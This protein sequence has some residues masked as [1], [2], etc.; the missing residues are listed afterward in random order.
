MEKYVLKSG[1]KDQSGPK[2][3]EVVHI[4]IDQGLNKWVY[5]IRWGG[6]QHSAFAGPSELSHLQALVKKFSGHEVHV[7]HE[8]CGFGYQISRWAQE[9]TEQTVRVTV[10]PPSTIEQE[11]GRR[12][13]TDRIDARKLARKL[14]LGELKGVWV[15]SVEQEQA[16]QIS[17]TQQQMAQ[18]RRRA[19]IRVR[20]LLRAHGYKAPPEAK[21][22]SAYERWLEQL[23]L[24]EALR[25]CAGHLRA[26]RKHAAASEQELLR[27]LRNMSQA[28]PYAKVVQTWTK[29]VVGIGW[30][31]A[32]RMLLELGD[33][34]RFP[35]RGSLP[36]YLGLTPSEYSTGD[37]VHRGAVLRCG[38]VRV[39][40]WLIES[41]WV[42]VR[43]DGQ[44]RELFFRI[45]GPS[46]ST[47]RR[48][49]AIVAI[50]HRLAI[51]LRALWKEALADS[52]QVQ[53]K[54]VA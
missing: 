27:Q 4:G 47:A 19:Q 33:V 22:W 16:R 18:E 32:I 8:A 10:V 3:G 38:P 41:A 42:A 36:H 5:A 25:Q 7:V 13:K 24:P 49:V 14:E 17:R 29:N 23:Q 15:P 37:G 39:R 45:A 11:P 26:L 53:S 54:A 50:G 31:S 51:K 43:R 30:L 48:K 12:V 20:S 34:Q 40:S 35:T 6:Q 44:L 2:P 46:Q 21:S 52:E 1:S 9:Y 28:R